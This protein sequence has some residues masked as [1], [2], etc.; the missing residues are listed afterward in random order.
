MSLIEGDINRRV[1]RY[2]PGNPNIY[3]LGSSVHI[4]PV[5][6]IG[7]FRLHEKQLKDMREQ[8]KL[9]NTLKELHEQKIRG[10][11]KLKDNS[12]IQ[13]H[14]LKEHTELNQVK[15]KIKEL[16][17]AIE[18]TESIVKEREHSYGLALEMLKEEGKSVEDVADRIGDISLK[19][20]TKE[21]QLD[22]EELEKI[23]GSIPVPV[24]A[25]KVQDV[26]RRFA[27][28]IIPEGNTNM[29]QEEINK[30][31]MLDVEKA[32]LE[33]SENQRLEEEKERVN[34]PLK[35]RDVKK[36]KLTPRRVK[37]DEAIRLRKDKR[38]AGFKRRRAARSNQ[39]K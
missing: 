36:N 33:K 10:L 14:L 31:F 22:Q 1:E 2:N 11:Q 32:R 12:Q 16:E 29:S 3:T 9:N 38:M 7:M 23:F 20:R 26:N 24:D 34:K 5:L 4:D 6:E 19:E 27:R 18:E 25:Y 35:K 8:L 39:N 13:T 17:K 21:E 15:Q 37:I 28:G 30:K